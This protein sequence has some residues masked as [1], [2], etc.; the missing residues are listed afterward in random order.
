MNSLQECQVLQV[1]GHRMPGLQ[2]I[3]G[4]RVIKTAG[5]NIQALVLTMKQ[6]RSKASKSEVSVEQPLNSGAR[7]VLG[8]NNMASCRFAFFS[9]ILDSQTFATH[10]PSK[11]GPAQNLFV[12]PQPTR[13]SG[14]GGLLLLSWI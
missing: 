6:V 9:G 1:T 3:F 10:L 14:S 8:N 13:A 12:F 5:G 11:N 2:T 7:C 4:A